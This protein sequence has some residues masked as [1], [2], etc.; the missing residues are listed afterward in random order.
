MDSQRS[1]PSPASP[2]HLFPLAFPAGPRGPADLP[3]DRPGPGVRLPDRACAGLPDGPT[4][5]EDDHA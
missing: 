4:H 5:R 2:S 3:S 1:L